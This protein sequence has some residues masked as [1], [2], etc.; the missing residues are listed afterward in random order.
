MIFFPRGH[1][2]SAEWLCCKWLQRALVRVF[3]TTWDFFTLVDHFFMSTAVKELG[4]R[5]EAEGFGFLLLPL[6]R[7]QQLHAKS[8]LSLLRVAGVTTA[9]LGAWMHGCLQGCTTVCMLPF[10]CC[11]K[12]HGHA[13]DS[14]LWFSLLSLGVRKRSNLGKKIKLKRSK[15]HLKAIL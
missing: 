2:D 7:L 4:C 12:L 11:P 1:E 10:T 6:S 13:G 14:K 15:I 8:S 5:E 9:L 3:Q